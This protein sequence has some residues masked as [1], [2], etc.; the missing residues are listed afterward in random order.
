[1][2]ISKKISAVALAGA[3][4]TTSIS[5][6]AVFTAKS[7]YAVSGERTGANEGVSQQKTVYPVTVDDNIGFMNQ[8]GKITKT[9]YRFTYLL[10]ENIQVKDGLYPFSAANGYMGYMDQSGRVVIKPTYQILGML[11][12]GMVMFRT[13]VKSKGKMLSGYMDKTGKVIA[14]PQ[15]VY[16]K[17]FS[18]GLAKVY[19][20]ENDY[21][22]L[23]KLG[24]MVIKPQFKSV[25]VMDGVGTFHEG[26]ASFR[27]A[28]GTG[29]YLWG[30]IDAK[31]NTV[32]KPVYSFATDYSEGLARVEANGKTGYIDKNG[33]EVIKPQF[34]F[35]G[36]F[37]EG[38]ASFSENGKTG[39]IDKT[40][41]VIIK[42]QFSGGT[43]FKEG[44][45]VG[46]LDN[47]MC[48]FDKSGKI[49]AKTD[50]SD[51]KG[52]NGGLSAVS[53][54][55]QYGVIDKT[56]KLIVKPQYR[57]IYDYYKGM[58]LA[59]DNKGYYLYVNSIGKVVW[60]ASKPT[61]R[62]GQG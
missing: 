60:K 48:I 52:F 18:E 37:S 19:V 13:M 53:Q 50:Y 21:G 55:G 27:I 38:L 4:V 40:G 16:A 44:L 11:S 1:M 61:V 35:A 5:A 2:K 39:Y 10:D 34:T 3:V 49:I 51:I 20:S 23:D 36:K 28:N 47:Q 22:Y 6:T 7:I 56:G 14:Q 33:N 31:G 29:G 43:D 45:A 32:V 30:F 62:G 57:Y 25:S 9:A 26:R 41:K 46:R 12:D 42:P 58:A 24:K 15:F 59:I 17:E 54:K 8:S